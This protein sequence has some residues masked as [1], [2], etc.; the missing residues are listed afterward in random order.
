MKT[1]AVRETKKDTVCTTNWFGR[2]WKTALLVAGTALTINSGGC[3]PSALEVLSKRVIEIDH[4]IE[5][6]RLNILTLKYAARALY[7]D[8]SYDQPLEACEISGIGKNLAHKDERIRRNSAMALCNIA[9]S[10]QDISAAMPYLTAAFPVSD[11]KTR[12]YVASARTYYYMRHEPKQVE[13]LLA[14]NKDPAITIAIVNTLGEMAWNSENI[15]PVM[16]SLASMLNKDNNLDVQKAVTATICKAAIA[17]Q[18][19]TIAI[20]PLL[21]IRAS[22][23]KKDERYVKADLAVRIHQCN[24]ANC[25]MPNSD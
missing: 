23:D 24:V 6:S 13:R 20:D 7:H 22:T 9:A 8:T 18:D 25:K 10:K 3:G 12:E 19:I 1:H 5:D 4:K 17:D 2:N 11:P 16:P 21:L 15:T 14:E